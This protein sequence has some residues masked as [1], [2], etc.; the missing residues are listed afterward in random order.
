[1]LEA[2]MQSISSSRVLSASAYLL[3]ITA[4]SIVVDKLLEG[5]NKT[6]LRAI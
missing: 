5:A 2:R 1:V 3:Y 4:A 6:E